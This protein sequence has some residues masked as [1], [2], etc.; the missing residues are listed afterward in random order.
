[1]T[2]A[3]LERALCNLG[4]VRARGK[5]WSV[6]SNALATQAIQ[7]EFGSLDA[8]LWGFVG[9][10]Q[11]VGTWERMDQIPTQTELSRT[12]SADLKLRGMRY[13]GPVITYSYLQA[14][15]VVNDHL[16]TCDRR[17][18]CRTS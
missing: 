2:D 8:Y 16:V 10:T 7:R 17:D 9:G 1:M 5:V 14:V 3:D 11:V 18:A 4:I 13:V 6:R 15:G 12:L